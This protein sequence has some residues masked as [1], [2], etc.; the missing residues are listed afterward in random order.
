MPFKDPIKKKEMQKIYHKTYRRKRVEWILNYKKDKCCSK[1]G[2]K[3]HPEILNFHHI[4][5]KHP[6]GNVSKLM[7]AG[8][9]LETLKKEIK[10]CILLCPNCHFWHHHKEHYDKWF[11]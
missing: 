10:K 9:P 8:F 2:W 4:K 6:Y 3:E 1:C 7:N 11:Y 5:K